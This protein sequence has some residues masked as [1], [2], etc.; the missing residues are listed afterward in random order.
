MH[1]GAE[2]PAVRDTEAAYARQD[3]GAVLISEQ[4]RPNGPPIHSR[5]RYRSGPTPFAPV[6]NWS[7]IWG[8]CCSDFRTKSDKRARGC[9]TGLRCAMAS[10]TRKGD[11]VATETIERGLEVLREELSDVD[12]AISHLQ[13]L[14]ILQGYSREYLGCCEAVVDIDC[15]ALAGCAIGPL[16]GTGMSVCTQAGETLIGS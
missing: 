15:R 7:D 3:S 10:T 6:R 14:A 12:Q 16:R 2:R 9:K 8:A 4:T 11:S 1:T 5:L 13:R